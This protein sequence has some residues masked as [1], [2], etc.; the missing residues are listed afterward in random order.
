MILPA[1]FEIIQLIELE[2]LETVTGVGGIND[3]ERS[4]WAS[5][6]MA[7]PVGTI[8]MTGAFLDMTMRLLGG[9]PP[10]PKGVP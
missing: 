3:R 4:S 2:E 8:V 6:A 9:T 7:G 5:G 1:N 10:A